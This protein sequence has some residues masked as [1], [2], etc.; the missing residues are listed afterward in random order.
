MVLSRGTF[1]G[2]RVTLERIDSERG[3]D[4]KFYGRLTIGR[5]APHRGHLGRD[6]DRAGPG[7]GPRGGHV[8]GAAGA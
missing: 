8:G 4:A 2:D 3:V 6:A 5:H 7:L 1:V